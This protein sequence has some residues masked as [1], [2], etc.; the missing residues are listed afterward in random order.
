MGKTVVFGEDAPLP[1]TGYHD[2]KLT[3]GGRHLKHRVPALRCA[4]RRPCTCV[5]GH[6]WVHYKCH[7]AGM[8]PGAVSP[9]EYRGLYYG[10]PTIINIGTILWGYTMEAQYFEDYQF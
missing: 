2:S 1:S 3:W 8:P 4:L 10:N 6:R 9:G 5:A 7:K